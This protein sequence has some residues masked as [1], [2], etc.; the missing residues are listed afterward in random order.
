MKKNKGLSV[1]QREKLAFVERLAYFHGIVNREDIL[2][3]FGISAASATNILS[4]YSQMAP[5]NL[6]YNIRLK[7]YE[8][9]K[10]FK[11]I[12]DVRMLIERIPV[13]TMPKLHDPDDNKAIER[14]AALSRAIQRTQSLT[15]TYSSASSGTSTRQ[16]I[17]V[18]FADNYLRWHLRAYDRKREKYADFV[19]R[20]IH[21]V[22]QIERDTIQE[23]EHP[24]NDKQWH[25]FIDLKI[26]AHPHNLT[27]AKSFTMNKKFYGVRIRAAMAGY[28]LQLWNV[29]CSPETRLRGKEYQYALENLTEVS[30]V[31]DLGLAPG[32]EGE[33]QMSGTYYDEEFSL[34]I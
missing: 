12:F 5:Q 31:A 14:I 20:R 24:K 4:V 28:F 8:I 21:E 11:P 7:G 22:S 27:D 6:S 26:K 16:I 15:I 1:A 19:F 3:R 18:A 25:S 30:A 33:T 32:Y 13:Y 29:D 17:P 9:G 10:S 34:G 2:N 23:H